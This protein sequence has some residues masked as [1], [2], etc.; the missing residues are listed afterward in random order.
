MYAMEYTFLSPFHFYPITRPLVRIPEE[1]EKSVES[2]RGEVIALTRDTIGRE[3]N[4][5]ERTSMPRE[6]GVRHSACLREREHIRHPI[7]PP[8]PPVQG[9]HGGVGYQENPQRNGSFGEARERYF[10]HA[11]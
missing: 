11:P 7:F 4:F 9:P 6:L 3:H 10:K 1:V 5:A 8:H 2:E